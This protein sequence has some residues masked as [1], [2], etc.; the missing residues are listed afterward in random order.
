MKR[1]TMDRHGAP[2]P[3][4]IDHNTINHT[5]RRLFEERQLRA[6]YLPLG[7]LLGEAAW[8]ILLFLFFTQAQGKGAKVDSLAIAS[9]MPV[10]RTLRWLERL[11]Q[12]EMVFAYRDEEN[13]D[14]VYLRLTAKGHLAMSRYLEKIA[15]RELR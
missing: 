3:R 15:M 11:E 13:S 10:S 7:D 1:D 6:E 14:E 9:R 5:A 4:T 12:K 8:D 2:R